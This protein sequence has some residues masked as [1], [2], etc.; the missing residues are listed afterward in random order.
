MI[1]ETCDVARHFFTWIFEEYLFLHIL[2]R[3]TRFEFVISNDNV[4]V[5]FP[6]TQTFKWWCECDYC[7]P[8]DMLFGAVDLMQTRMFT[9]KA[10]ESLAFWRYECKVEKKDEHGLRWAITAIH[11]NVSSP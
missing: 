11:E 1:C 5:W 4:V 10:K 3:R 6:H 2:Q 7:V 8:D 9:E